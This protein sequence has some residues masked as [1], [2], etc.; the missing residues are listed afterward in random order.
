MVIQKLVVVAKFAISLTVNWIDFT[1]LA[2]LFVFFVILL[3]HPDHFQ[4]FPN[5]IVYGI[6]TTA[7]FASIAVISKD[8]VLVALAANP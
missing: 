5:L 2:F 6:A 8:V 4:L 7:F 3:V 1:Q